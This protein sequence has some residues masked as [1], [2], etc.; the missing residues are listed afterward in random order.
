LAKIEKEIFSLYNNPKEENYLIL[1]IK[2]K[3]VSNGFITLVNEVINNELFFN[4]FTNGEIN[5]R[6]EEMTNESFRIIQEISA[7][8]TSEDDNQLNIDFLE[9]YNQ[10]FDTRL[11]TKASEIKGIPNKEILFLLDER[12]NNPFDSPYISLEYLGYCIEFGLLMLDV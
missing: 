8:I 11:I 5:S 9:N 12:K 3:N 10:V 1:L 4:L 2:L 6:I 7:F